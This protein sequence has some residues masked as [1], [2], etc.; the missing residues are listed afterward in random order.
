M[1]TTTKFTGNRPL[2]NTSKL[3]LSQKRFVEQCAKTLSKQ[4]SNFEERPNFGY[5]MWRNEEDFGAAIFPTEDVN[6][7][8]QELRN[9]WQE[10]TYPQKGDVYDRDWFVNNGGEQ[11]G[12][13]FDMLA[14]GGV[15]PWPNA[16]AVFTKQGDV[17]VVTD[18]ITV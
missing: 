17:C 6:H 18:T 16:Q 3:A 15:W 11:A 8:E 12:I 14:E 10:P 9:L 13:S 4:F 5:V 7:A 1:I 2:F